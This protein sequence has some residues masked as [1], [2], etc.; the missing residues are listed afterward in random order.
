MS[1]LRT[2][3]MFGT[4]MYYNILSRQSVLS[5]CALSEYCLYQR[6]PVSRFCVVKHNAI[7]HTRFMSTKRKL[8]SKDS[9]KSLQKAHE[10]DHVE[11]CSLKTGSQPGSDASMVA[12]QPDRSDGKDNTTSGQQATEIL[13][14]L[15]PD[16]QKRLQVLQLEYDVWWSMGTRVPSKMSDDMWLHLLTHCLTPSSRRKIYHF[17][18]KREN[19]ILK[20]EEKHKARSEVHKDRQQQ[21][22]QEN[23]TISEEDAQWRRNRLLAPIAESKMHKHFNNNI[24]FAAVH[25]PHLA[26]DLGFGADMREREVRN[27]FSQLLDCHGFNK[28]QR[29]PFHLHFCGA[30]GQDPWL[31]DNLESRLTEVP[32]TLTPDEVFTQYPAKSLVYL[33]PNAPKMLETFDHDAV[34]VLGGI[35]DQS[36]ELPLTFA[37]A[38]KLK[39][40][41]RKLPLDKYL[42]WKIGSK[43][44]TLDQMV[45]ILYTF[46]D[47]GDWLQAFT[48]VPKRKF[49][50]R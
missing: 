40:Q 42:I 22:E 23:V 14:Q 45:K 47:T 7:K 17:W 19:T 25:G 33:S 18:T 28:Q 24:A 4:R 50:W 12:D 48:H 21:R 10:P 9:N 36:Q 37:K 2:G 20:K 46:K 44:L 16:D 3:Y 49:D 34:Y 5:T 38:K 26:I 43:A 15:G 41:T 30:P 6:E 29:E 13:S 1:T 11:G 32:Y 8:E 35:V 31:W 27:L 39:V